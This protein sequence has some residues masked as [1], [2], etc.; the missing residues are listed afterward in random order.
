MFLY[1][2]GNYTKKPLIEQNNIKTDNNKTTIVMRFWSRIQK[3]LTL[4]ITHE[5]FFLT[6]NI[7]SV[8]FTFDSG[9]TLYK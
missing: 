1:I 9:Q 8:S 2:T 4:L 3:I 7:V 5:W 6:I